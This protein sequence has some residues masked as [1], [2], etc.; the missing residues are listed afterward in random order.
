M[1]KTL[2]LLSAVACVL[3]CTTGGGPSGEFLSADLNF[4]PVEYDEEYIYLDVSTGKKAANSKIYEDVDYFYN[5]FAVV[6]KD[7]SLSL[8]NKEFQVINK[9]PLSQATIFREGLAYVVQPGEHIKAMNQSG[10]YVFTLDE[11]ATA[12]L[13]NDGVSVFETEDEGYG[14]VDPSGTIL[15]TPGEYT[16]MIPIGLDGMLCAAKETKNGEKWGVIDYQGN[17][18]IPFEYEELIPVGIMNIANYNIGG[19]KGLF[20]FS[21]KGDEYGVMDTNE[22][23]ILPPSYAAIYQQPD[24]SFFFGKDYSS[25]GIRVGWMNGKGEEIISPLFSE[26]FPFIYTKV[27][28]AKD[29]SEDEYGIIDKKGDWVLNPKFQYATGF[30]DDRLAIVRNN[31]D[32]FGL[33]NEKGEYAVRARYDELIAMGKGLYIA[34]EDGTQGIINSKGDFVVKMSDLYTFYPPV[35]VFS[36]DGLSVTSEYIDINAVVDKMM[37]DINLLKD[38]SP[39]KE[40]YEST[41][42]VDLEGYGWKDLKYDYCKY[43]SVTLSAYADYEYGYSFYDGEYVDRYLTSLKADFDLNYGKISDSAYL[44]YNELAKR[45]GVSATMDKSGEITGDTTFTPSFLENCHAELNQ[46]FDILITP[47]SGKFK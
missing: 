2:S 40:H 3:G 38:D 17:E 11:A 19:G 46:D 41:F 21:K 39:S 25:K 47:D 1:K 30:N 5:G 34:K 43:Y 23:E 13:F 33:I 8:I 12:Y 4:I 15:I 29:P 27:T 18:I 31:S 44:I 28:I 10:E 14:L 26:A 22:E 20:L 42:S 36:K 32:K 24:G 6:K 45:L 16:D 37:K 35:R 9:D 7:G